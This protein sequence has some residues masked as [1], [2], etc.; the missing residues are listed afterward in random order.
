[1][2][3]ATDKDGK[4]GAAGTDGGSDAGKQAAVVAD[5]GKQVPAPKEVKEGAAVAGG[6]ASKNLDTTSKAVRLQG[7]SDE[8]P[9]EAELFELS[10]SALKKRL[11]RHTAKELKAAFGTSDLGDIKKRLDKAASLEKDDE[12]RKRAEMTEKQKLE[13]DL[14]ASRQREADANRRALRVQEDRIV[15][16]EENRITKI[17]EK[18]VD[19]D[20][21]VVEVIF[22]RLGKFLRSEFTDD[23]LKKLPDAKIEKWFKE[24][25]TEHP[26]HAREHRN[27]GDDTGAAA[28]STTAKPAPKKVPLTNGPETG[29]RPGKGDVSGTAQTT[30]FSPSKGTPMTSQQARAAAAKEGYRW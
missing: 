8:I 12:E 17:A 26:K 16:K 5:A 4:E 6:A 2:A 21:D 9:E 13:A 1:M 22:K 3:T 15:E 29:D 28:A 24:Y 18:Y 10:A 14:K 25:A 19:T 20:P 30:N 23:Q 11:S 7:D 27:A